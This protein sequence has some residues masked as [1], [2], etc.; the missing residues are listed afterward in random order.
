ME[1]PPKIMTVGC[2]GHRQIPPAAMDLVSDG[3]RTEIERYPVETLVGVCSLAVGADQLFARAVLD[4]GGRLHAVIPSHGY[5]STFSP[6][7][8]TTFRSLLDR[9]D[10]VEVL[11]F[12]EP[13]AAAF[14]AAG[15]RVADLSDL[16]IA[17]WDGRAA[18]GRGGTAD[19]LA[20]ARGRARN[21][22]V[23]WPIHG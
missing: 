19:A 21:I 4:V 17:V 14:G 10:V 16:L 22:V 9:A 7:D 2:T 20:Y 3:I 8:R 1:P 13:C 18:D 11:E 23:V 15:N 12:H 6:T 5:E